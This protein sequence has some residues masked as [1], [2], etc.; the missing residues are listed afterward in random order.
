[1]GINSTAMFA[2]NPY[3]RSV[4]AECGYSITFTTCDTMSEREAV[5]LRQ[6][7]LRG[8][9]ESRRWWLAFWLSVAAM[10]VIGGL[11]T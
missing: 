9:L 1:M 3:A 7:R 5:E 8:R 4:L 2:D 6:S 10:A 11:L